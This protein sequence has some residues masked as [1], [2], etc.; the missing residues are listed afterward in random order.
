MELGEGKLSP[1]PAPDPPRQCLFIKIPGSMCPLW[2][3]KGW[4]RQ[5]NRTAAR[6]WGSSLVPAL[7]KS[8]NFSGPQCSHLCCGDTLTFL[9]RHLWG[10][11]AL[12]HFS[13]APLVLSLAS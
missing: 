8:L 5:E 1:G 7:S 11:D 2:F 3:E 9:P 12:M 6:R 13:G 4:C 10:G